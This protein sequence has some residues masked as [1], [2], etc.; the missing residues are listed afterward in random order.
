MGSGGTIHPHERT[1][2][3]LGGARRRGPPAVP[4]EHVEGAPVSELGETLR[5]ARQKHNLSLAEAAEGTRIKI[6]FL[7]ALENG[8][9]SLLPGP[10]YVTG[11]LRNY[12][13]YLG[14]H[15]DDLVQEFHGSRP[16]PQPMVKAAT[17]VLASGYE[18]QNRTRLLWA[19]SALALILIAGYTIKHYRESTQNAY[20]SPL[21][22]TP[23]NLGATI[24]IQNHPAHQVAAIHNV[25]LWL[26]ATDAVWVRVTADGARRFE[27]ILHAYTAGRYWQARHSI[28]VATY[29]G[30]RLQVIYDGRN[31]GRFS[32]RAGLTVRVGTPTGWQLAS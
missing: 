19:L 22:V 23:A 15:P 14:L 6:T 11:F 31:L 3:W 30:P 1:A 13:R 32:S 24:A 29:N 10:A 8:D 28:Y 25:R 5:G 20:S 18:R 27:G 16:V 9:Y 26:K 17:R 4:S 2:G 21:N 12:A 7:E